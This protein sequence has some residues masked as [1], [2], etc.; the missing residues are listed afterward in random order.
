MG[1]HLDWEVEAEQTH[2]QRAGEE[3]LS[4]RK[5][6]LAR[7]RFLLFILVLLGIFAGLVGV[8]VWRLQALDSQ[9]EQAL[10]S[11]VEA[12]VVALRLGDFIAFSSAQRSASG[13]W[14][15]SQQQRQC[16]PDAAVPVMQRPQCQQLGAHIRLRQYNDGTAYSQ[17]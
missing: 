10:R 15:Q 6:R 17:D 4:A 5:R 14:L 11:T 7:L 9:V 1:I 12:E 8:V 3:P 13:D 16:Q 2:T